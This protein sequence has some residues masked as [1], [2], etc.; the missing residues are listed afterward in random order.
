M[1]GNRENIQKAQELERLIEQTRKRVDQL[2]AD[3]MKY[4][5]T[6]QISSMERTV[7]N[8]QIFIKNPKVLPHFQK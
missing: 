8:I 6:G 4:A 5:Q 3:G 1:T 7:T 2:V